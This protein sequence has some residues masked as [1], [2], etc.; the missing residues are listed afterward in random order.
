MLHEWRPDSR[1]AVR[2]ALSDLLGTEIQAGRPAAAETIAEI[3]RSFASLELPEQA[4]HPAASSRL[5]PISPG[6]CSENPATYHLACAR[7]YV[8]VGA[9]EKAEAEFQASFA[10]D[11]HMTDAYIGLARLRYPGQDYVAWLRRFHD[12][13]CPR[14]YL[15][16]GVEKGG[17]LALARPPT[18][19]IGVD[20]DPQVEVLFE[21]ETSVFKSS[22]DKFFLGDQL[23]T[24]LGQ[25]HLKL[26]FIDGLHVFE[27]SLRDFMNIERFCGKDSVVLFHDAIPVN[28]I[29]QNPDRQT[30]FYTGD[31]WKTVLCLKSFRQDL[32]VFT[33][34]TPLTGLTVVLGLDSNSRV[35]EE[36]YDE[37]V[38]RFGAAAYSELQGREKETLSMVPNDWDVVRTRLK[39]HGILSD[40]V[41]R[42]L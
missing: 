38:R 21:T 40:L 25:M 1:D 23:R 22:S 9:R 3:A 12:A 31:V 19:A 30:D 26:A 17:T 34:A 33:I 2:A 29:T 13:L 11:I 39:R 41:P 36:R 14:Y 6:R 27:Q 18:I 35:L 42:P 5:A 37:A 24:V 15:E 20:P 7:A 32:D 10:A 16:I 28:E 8:I 4:F